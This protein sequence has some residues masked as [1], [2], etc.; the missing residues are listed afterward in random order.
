MKTKTFLALASLAVLA[1]SANA[2]ANQ[3]DSDTYVLPT[4]VVTAPRYQ[5]VELEIKARLNEL[6]QQASAPVVITPALT[7]PR[8][9]TIES[10]KLVEALRA[11]APK[12]I[13]KS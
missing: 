1:S 6:R 7:L 3:T 10:N 4:Y 2:A 8:A 5:P 11:S 9:R 12:I 13:A